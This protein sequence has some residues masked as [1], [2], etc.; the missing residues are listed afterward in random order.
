[1]KSP[2]FRVAV[3]IKAATFVND[4]FKKCKA[5]VS[6]LQGFADGFDQSRLD[7]SLDNNLEPYPEM[8]PKADTDQADEFEALIAEVEN[9]S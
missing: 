2:V 8:A 1:M 6:K 5:Q 7:P 3:E 4:G 9:M